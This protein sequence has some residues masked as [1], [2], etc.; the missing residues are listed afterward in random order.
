MEAL[1]LPELVKIRTSCSDV[2]DRV[3]K[4]KFAWQT[5]KILSPLKTIDEPFIFY[6][7]GNRIEINALHVFRDILD[8]FG[9]LI[10]NLEVDLHNI[11]E[12]DRFEIGRQVV[13]SCSETL[14]QLNLVN[15]DLSAFTENGS[16][17][18]NVE[19]VTFSGDV[20]YSQSGTINLNQFLPKMRS[21]SFDSISVCN[22][23]LF[24]TEFS[25]LERLF[26]KFSSWTPNEFKKILTEKLLKKNEQIE[27]VHL[28]NSDVK[29]LKAIKSSSKPKVLKI[30]RLVKNDQTGDNEENSNDDN[31]IFD[32]LNEV[33]LNFVEDFELNEFIEFIESSLANVTKLQ[34]KQGV[35]NAQQLIKLA[36]A[37]PNLQE[38]SLDCDVDALPHNI[39]KFMDFSGTLNKLYLKASNETTH[40]T[41]REQLTDKWIVTEIVLNEN[42]SGI[43]IERR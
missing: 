2:A 25:N 35:V 42:L 40:N 21:L 18:K 20:T 29:F 24:D 34:L 33:E 26:V 11:K 27:Y 14:P 41:L 12:N 32:G 31:V 10:S 19:N 3:F 28:V 4:S 13:R 5:F 7:D 15:C 1:S 36:S 22:S 9:H 30:Q 8:A 37:S 17:L 39:T 16:S 6:F 38:A 43:S 23:N